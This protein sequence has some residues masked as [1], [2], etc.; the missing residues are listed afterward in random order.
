MEID[1]ID[2]HILQELQRDARQANT[3]LAKKV[4]VSPSTV[5]NRIRA[6]E[7]SGVLR[8]YH[9]DV[10]PVALGRTVE[11]LVSVRLR[12]KTPEA[13][14]E[15]LDAIWGLEETVAVWLVTGDTDVMIHLS[16]R[17]MADLSETVLRSIAAAPNVADEKSAVVFTHRSRRAL[18]AL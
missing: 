7:S 5:V 6:L 15:F 4:G 12:P 13:V 17:N 3:A 9:A 16:V 14:D 8:G 18:P 2:G 10:A 11:A 1:E